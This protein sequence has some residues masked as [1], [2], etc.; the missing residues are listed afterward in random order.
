MKMLVTPPSSQRKQI[1]RELE[2]RETTANYDLWVFFYKRRYVVL[3]S[4]LSRGEGYSTP[5]AV[6]CGC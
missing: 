2:E 6:W 5:A 4:L 3:V 1:N